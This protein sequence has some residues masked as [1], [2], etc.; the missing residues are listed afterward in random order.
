MTNLKKHMQLFVVLLA[1]LL[2]HPWSASAIKADEKSPAASGT[3]SNTVSYVFDKDTGTLT[4]SGSGYTPYYYYDSVFRNCTTIRHIVIE[5]GITN[6]RQYLFESLTGVES[7]SIPS[8]VTSIDCDAFADTDVIGSGFTVSSDNENFCSIDGSLFNKKQTTLY[9]YVDKSADTYEDYTLPD[10]VTSVLSNAFCSDITLGTLTLKGGEKLEIDDCAL[11][12]PQ[13]KHIVLGEGITYLGIKSRLS[14]DTLLDTEITVP[15]TL[16]KFKNDATNI[17]ENIKFEKINVAKG[18]PNYYDI[19]GVVIE[20]SS[21]TLIFYPRGKKDTSYTT[22]ED[23]TAIAEYAIVNH[24]LT[25]VTLTENIQKLSKCAIYGNAIETYTVKNPFIECETKVFGTNNLLP[26]LTTIKTYQHSTF[27]DY[28]YQNYIAMMDKLS[29]FPDCETHTPDPD[30]H[31]DPTCT[32]DGKDLCH[33][34]GA[35]I[36]NASLKKL[37]HDYTTT[38]VP[39]TC[40]S[41]GYTI[42]TCTRGDS[43][44]TDNETEKTTE[45]V[46]SDTPEYNADTNEEIHHCIYENS[47]EVPIGQQL[48]ETTH[49]YLNNFS[50]TYEL[51]YPGAKQIKI[52]F[53]GNSQ[54]SL[55]EYLY[56]YKDSISEQNRLDF[57]T[58]GSFRN[59]EFMIDTDHLIMTFTSDSSDT[60]YG[61]K[62]ISATAI[63][64]GCGYTEKKAHTTHTET[65]SSDTDSTCITHGITTYKCTICGAVRN[66]EKAL[67]EHVTSSAYCMKPTCTRDGYY[68][69]S[70]CHTR[71]EIDDP[72]LKKLGHD[73]TDTVFAP[74]CIT[75]GCTLHL[76]NR[77]KSPCTEYTLPKK[78]SHTLSDVTYDADTNE[79]VRSCTTG[80]TPVTIT[81]NLPETSHPVNVAYTYDIT[82][83]PGAKRIEITFDEQSDLSSENNYIAVYSVNGEQKAWIDELTGDLASKTVSFDTDVVCLYGVFK[84]RNDYYGY[85][86]KSITAYFDPCD[87][88]ERTSHTEH[89]ETV[90]KD[91]DSTCQVK[92]ETTYRCQLCKN[93]RTVYK[94]LSDHKYKNGK[95]Q[96]CDEEHPVGTFSNIKISEFGIL[97]W[98]AVENAEYYDVALRK[99]DG[100]SVSY[101]TIATHLT[102]LELD[103]SS[104]ITDGQTYSI[105]FT[106]VSE[107][108]NDQSQNEDSGYQFTYHAHKHDFGTNEPVCSTCGATNPDYIKPGTPV[109]PSDPSQNPIKE[110]AADSS[111]TDPTMTDPSATAPSGNTQVSDST[112]ASPDGTVKA[113]KASSLKSLK[114][115][116]RS[117]I[118]KWKKISGAN[119]YQI[120]LATDKKFKKNKKTVTIKKQISRTTV[121]KLKTKKKYYVRIRTYKIINGKKVYASWSKAKAVKTK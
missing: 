28:L 7:V 81:E 51:S 23:I 83:Y 114:G 71:M 116:K 117:I 10:S 118:I 89:T 110:P 121:K 93:E 34:C 48:P 119:G 70:V 59:S 60:A 15:S 88:I 104:Y 21:N 92:G 22:P 8:T 26:A 12:E 91:T 85:K 74:T 103:L 9:K 55:G 108:Y 99:E 44:C 68:S 50:K 84:D 35:E 62:I 98:D 69:C 80:S 86:I 36:E 65:I 17:F 56:F 33:I 76:C 38:V 109:T 2:L 79:E 95:C 107:T 106:A 52:K 4:L 64:D 16:N 53:D 32:E 45:H 113:P 100:S 57:P 67:G 66:V 61:F 111:I 63:L 87:H 96:W 40:A 78:T 18:N 11:R 19:N 47:V 25:S 41:K 3:L 115:K 27:K 101:Q 72:A 73:Y 37:G 20:R 29:Y 46:F 42:Y 120:V 94:D 24:N 105:R 102:A 30:R 43:T 75:E 39:P 14:E 5:E 58:G 6:L 1:F 13:L 90:I 77:C 97:T 112:S 54:T 49:P 82:G 31:V